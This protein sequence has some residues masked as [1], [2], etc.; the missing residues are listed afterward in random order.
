MAKV[1]NMIMRFGASDSPDV[2]S[3]RMYMEEAP[4]D[5]TYESEMFDLGNVNEVD[6]SKLPGMT[7]KDGVFNIGITAVDDAG[8]ESSM[9]RANDV[10]FDFV[11]PNPPGE[12]TFE[13]S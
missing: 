2:A 4:N 13:I 8:N 5:V 6:I 7:T 1:K 12:I 11:A 10:P 3:Y 9:S